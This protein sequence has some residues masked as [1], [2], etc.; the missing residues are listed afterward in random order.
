[1]AGILSQCIRVGVDSA[2]RWGG[3][4]SGAMEQPWA[5]DLHITAR[6]WQGIID[7]SRLWVP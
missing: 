7:Q 1:M 3:C 6:V 5:G 4:V 2:P